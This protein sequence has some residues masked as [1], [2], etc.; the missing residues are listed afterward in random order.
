MRGRAGIGVL[1]GRRLA[2]AN[3][4]RRLASATPSVEQIRIPRQIYAAFRNAVALL[5]EFQRCRQLMINRDT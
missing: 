3:V 5:D 2:S 1:V 4:G